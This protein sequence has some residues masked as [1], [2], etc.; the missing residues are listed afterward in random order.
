[1]ILLLHLFSMVSCM[2]YW[3]SCLM[4]ALPFLSEGGG[5]Q[6]NTQSQKATSMGG[7]VTGNALDASV[8]FYNPGGMSMLDSN[9]FNLGL[10]ALMPGTAFLGLT[11]G[12]EDMKSKVYLPAYFYGLYFLD[13]KSSIGLSVNSPFGLGTEWEDQWSGRYISTKAKLT[14][15]FIQP[16]LGYKISDRISIGV[17]PVFVLG[18]ADLNKALPVTG[19]DGV[20]AT[21]ELKGNGNGF[22]VNGGVMMAFGKTSV[23]LNY[24]SSVKIKLED[25]EADFNNVPSSLISNGTFVNSASFNSEITLPAVASIGIGYKVNEELLVNLDLNYTFWSVYDSLNF[26]FPD[27]SSLDSRNARAY[28]NSLAVRLG[29]QYNYSER[30]KIRG[31]L[32]FDQSPVQDGYV[33]PELPDADRLIVSAGFTLKMKKGWSVEGTL[34]FEDVRE[35]KEENNVQN[36]FNGTYKSYLYGA[37]VG[38]Q[39]AF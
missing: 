1:M 34:L 23:G 31:G 32:A 13:E 3:M 19:A 29:A 2:K 33:S 20:E 35:R 38:V 7:S 37:G 22:G 15:L 27:H 16:S 26:L 4:L 11:G 5:F 6:I 8:V 9:T 25:G 30:L 10:S 17:G 28:E 12:Q 39:Y 36:N 18:N 21:A 24:R 14:T